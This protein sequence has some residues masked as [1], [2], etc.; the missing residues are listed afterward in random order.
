MNTP[1]LSAKLDALAATLDLVASHD[2]GGIAAALTRGAGRHAL[3]IGSG[4]SAVA[5]EYLVRCR[6]T[7]GFG[8]TTVATPMQGVLDHHRL[9][10][11]DAWLFSAGADNPDA[12]A[13]AQA[14]D[15]RGA[16]TI[17]LVTRNP[18]GAAAAIVARSNGTINSVPVADVKDGYLA[19]H[20]LLAMTTALLIASHVASRETCT[21][22][23]ALNAVASRLVASRDA[24]HRGLLAERWTGLR[25]TDTI[26]IAADP[27]LRPVASLLDTSLWE[28][29]LCPVQTTDFRNLAHGRHAW[30]HHRPD[31]TA[32]LALT[33]VNSRTAWTAIETV[34]PGGVRRDVID[35]GSGGRLDNLL[36]IIDGLSHIEAI[37]E[38]LGI[39]PGKPG[40]GDFGRAIYDDRSLETTAAELRPRLRHKRAAI[41][42]ADGLLANDPNLSAIGDQRLETLAAAT[43]GGAV[44]DYDGTIVTT[45]GRFDPP[46]QEIIDELVRLHRAGVRLGIATGRGGSASEDLR[47]V[48]P[49]DVLSAL[50][51][52]YYNGGHLR[53]ADI[54]IKNDPPSQDPAI[55]ATAAWLNGRDDLFAN[56]KFKSGPVQIGVEMDKLRHPY[57]FPL[58]MADCPQV[59]SGA[60]RISASGH[61]FDI[62]PATSCK[63]AIVEAVRREAGPN[64]A[65]LCF[66][67]SGSR[68]GN[69]YTL[70][71]H[72]HG[73][74]VGEVCG[75]AD[76]C[77][78]L[79]G[80]ALTGPDALLRT[81]R[82]LVASSTGEI[83]LD[84][85]ALTLDKP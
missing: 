75:A 65:V 66:G 28:A 9:D 21:A 16:A 81:L 1:V 22:T 34:L 55:A 10:A 76:G 78:S 80:G 49:P 32:V 25:T 60:V 18:D 2:V 26:I 30:L 83:R 44:F 3:A 12:C 52:G 15:D 41:A 42:K 68:S 4:G 7:L 14:L 17:N 59:A 23:E 13:I 85:A 47:K 35:Y 63:S 29:S 48:L 67:D 45:E 31:D 6:D 19:T 71:A 33:A 72:P 46:S 61:S 73:I 43:V 11:T 64:A 37:G 54:N 5:A 69:D 79:F 39:D 40:I 58:D 38:V 20:S 57:R 53:T 24:G 50:L 77:W 82:A 62:I 84:T 27:S 70:L 8:P 51:I 74:S 56:K 36:G